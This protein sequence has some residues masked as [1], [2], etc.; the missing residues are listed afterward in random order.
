MVA[1]AFVQTGETEARGPRL[2]L[3]SLVWLEQTAGG[4]FQR[5]TIEI[6]GHHVTLDAAD[7][8]LDGDV[9][10]VV[11]NFRARNDAWVDVWENL[12]PSPPGPR[13]RSR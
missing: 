9:D 7:Y 8:D 10:I 2:R 4:R 12:G 11:G 5:H 1:A 13:G 3:P 6:G